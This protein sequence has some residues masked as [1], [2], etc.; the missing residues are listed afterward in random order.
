MPSTASAQQRLP[1]HAPYDTG[2]EALLLRLENPAQRIRSFADSSSQILAPVCPVPGLGDLTPP[3]ASVPSA[4]PPAA[5]STTDPTALLPQP[6]FGLLDAAGPPASTAAALTSAPMSLLQ[7][8]WGVPGGLEG[9]VQKQPPQPA[10]SAA[11]AAAAAAAAQV[12]STPKTEAGAAWLMQQVLPPLSQAPASSQPLQHPSAMWPWGT[13]AE[14]QQ[15]GAAQGAHAAAAPASIA[16][17]SRVS[18]HRPGGGAPLRATAPHFDGS[19]LRTQGGPLQAPTPAAP[20]PHL[21]Q[22]QQQQQQQRKLDP[23]PQLPASLFEDDDDGGSLGF[24]SGGGGPGPGVQ[25]ANPPPLA[26]QHQAAAS[27][28]ANK[29]GMGSGKGEGMGGGVV[30]PPRPGSSALP[31]RPPPG[32]RGGHRR[33]AS[34]GGSA[35]AADNGPTAV[36]S[37]STGGTSG[38][39]LARTASALPNG[40]A[41][42]PPPPPP[43]PPHSF[44][45]FNAMDFYG[46]FVPSMY[47]PGGPAATAAAAAASA[48]GFWPPPRPPHADPTPMVPQPHTH[49]GGRMG[50]HARSYRA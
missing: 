17:N 46:A 33:S 7:D 23:L 28:A 30:I 15:Q 4:P 1:L 47:G 39:G 40:F 14:Q 43:Q 48:T 6:P 13:A 50:G 31:V 44:F 37:R 3:L 36:P 25:P 42:Q 19:G 5:A 2:L 34:G 45:P 26:H 21:R 10:A 11:A 22:N 29:A 41:P 8:V 12:G 9:S 27:S 24:S 16:P 38:S 35:V 49:R 20:Q 32:G 18:P